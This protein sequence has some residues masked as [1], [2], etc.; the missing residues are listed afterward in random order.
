VWF[1][2]PRTV[3][4]FAEPAILANARAPR[5]VRGMSDEAENPEPE[6]AAPRTGFPLVVL[7]VIG[8]CLA[9][10]AP[11]LNYKHGEDD[12]VIYVMLTANWLQTGNYSIQGT[13][14]V[15]KL[16]QYMY[17]RPLFHHPPLYPILLAPF[18]L[19]QT[20]GAAVIIGWFGHVLAILAVALVGRRLLARGDPEFSAWSPCFVL[21][22]VGVAVDPLLVFTTR[23][24]WID[25]LM[26]GLLAM[27]VVL[28][29]LAADTR[30]RKLCYLIGGLCLA[31]AA[32]CKLTAC[33]FTA[34]ILLVIFMNEKD[35]K[36]R[37]IATFLAGLPGL[38]LVLPW[39]IVF[40]QQ[41]GTIYPYWV[42]DDPAAIAANPFVQNVLDRGYFF[43]FYR[44]PLLQPLALIC[45]VVWARRWRDTRHAEIAMGLAWVLGFLALISALGGGVG[46]IMRYLTP[47]AAGI[48]VFY[49]AL[50]ARY[51]QWRQP[52]LTFGL[53][54]VVF[55]A[56][57]GAIY[58]VM[59]IV[60]DMGGI[61]SLGK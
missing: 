1:V 5:K 46:R 3:T 13:E 55:A 8:L 17:N 26:S 21:P 33:A 36:Q 57:N 19:L 49:Y 34:I 14:I 11:T 30:R 43:F 58:L 24:L 40:Y 38:C 7:L 10:K 45:L 31:L 35:W 41:Y 22:L 2:K 60:D 42:N 32:L 47:L 37:G 56:F 6:I 51:P 23:K 18:L 20:L 50:L 48:Y 27:A 4:P 61:F 16:S 9:L 29:Y 39:L 53:I 25:P 52:M 54:A 12:E 15:P 59:P 44:L 28:V